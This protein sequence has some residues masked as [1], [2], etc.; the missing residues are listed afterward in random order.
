MLR[1]FHKHRT[2]ITKL[3]FFLFC[4][5]LKSLLRPSSLT[6]IW[7]TWQSCE[8]AKNPL[9]SRGK[10]IYLFSFSSPSWWTSQAFGLVWNLQCLAT[11][12]LQDNASLGPKM[13][14]R[15]AESS[16]IN[17]VSAL[18][19]LVQVVVETGWKGD[20][21]SSRD[22]R[23]VDA[24]ILWYLLELFSDMDELYTTFW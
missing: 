13:V 1:L 5:F 24:L 11:C 10:N 12:S 17:I 20:Y 9:V 8:S 19:L 15:R 6:S 21:F 4:G 3:S 16:C 14:K 22:W 23:H 18:C 7:R 2:F